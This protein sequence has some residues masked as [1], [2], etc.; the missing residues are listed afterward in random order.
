MLTA[1]LGD[2]AVALFGLLQDGDDLLVC[3][4]A[5]LRIGKLVF[6]HLSILPFGSILTAL[7]VQFMGDRSRRFTLER[8]V[9]DPNPFLLAGK[10][11]VL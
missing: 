8:Y 2:W 6:L 5:L 3:Q 1:D 11:H 4:E 9:A 10:R 7:M